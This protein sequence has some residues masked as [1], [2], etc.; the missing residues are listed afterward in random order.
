M[1]ASDKTK[2]TYS[3]I[4]NN[5]VKNDIKIA[6]IS[7]VHISDKTKEKELEFIVKLLYLNKPNYIC[8]LGDLIDSPKVID[9]N[10]E[11][12]INFLKELSKIS[13]IFIVL[14]NHDY[15]TRNNN[16]CKEDYNKDFYE[17]ID[18]MNNIN[19]LND[20][21]IYLKDITIMGYME[22]YNVYHDRNINS[23]YNDFSKKDNL[24]KINNNNPNIALIHSPEPL[25]YLNNMN[26]F[27]SYDL[28]LSGHYHNGCMP[29][30][31]ENIW[32]IKNG[33]IITSTKEIFPK[34][35]RGIQKLKNGSYLLHNGGWIK[36]SQSTPKKLHFLDKLCNRQLDI[37]TLTNKRDN[38]KIYSKKIN[39]DY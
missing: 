35:V 31:L 6:S 37:T 2:I 18:N 29:S 34:D 38:E 22:K 13:P 39:N 5:K 9:T 24:Y 1:T 16:I 36:L 20:K 14:G 21:I 33:G 3:N 26:L 11:K 12:I 32:P 4:Y 25:K 10:E 17:K 30:F 23:F 28:I 8:I 15:I 19:V 7:D 27:N